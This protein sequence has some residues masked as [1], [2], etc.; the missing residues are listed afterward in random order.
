LRDHGAAGRRANAGH[1]SVDQLKVMCA[2]ERC[3]IPVLG[4]HVVRSEDCTHT[5]LQ[6][7]PYGQFLD[8]ELA[9]E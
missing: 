9:S 7:M 4:G 8:G 1:V 3:R 5:G 6:P 2:I